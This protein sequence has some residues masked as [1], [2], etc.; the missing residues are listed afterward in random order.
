MSG[1]VYG[2]CDNKCKHEVIKKDSVKLLWSNPNPAEAMGKTTVNLLDNDFDIYE[3]FF[4]TKNDE[5]TLQS[6]KSVK[7][8]G[9]QL[10]TNNGY[11]NKSA[12]RGLYGGTDTI[13]IE[14]AYAGSTTEA[15][16][17]LIP[18]YIIGYKTG[19]FE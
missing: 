5:T 19:L 12:S 10:I 9:C 18:V 4:K 7:G 1:E 2:F 14:V 8:Y 16:E 6:T 3:V 13:G 11:F 17:Y 15:N